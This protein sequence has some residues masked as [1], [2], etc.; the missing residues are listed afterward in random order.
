MEA[1]MEKKRYIG[2]RA[3]EA[4]YRRLRREAQ[5]RGGASMGAVLRQMLEAYLKEC[6]DGLR[7]VTQ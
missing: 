1:E 7:R 2:F 5:A 3:D 4:L 6:E